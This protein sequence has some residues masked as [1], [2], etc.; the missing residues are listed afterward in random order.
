MRALSLAAAAETIR[1][2]GLVVFPTETVYGLGGDATDSRAVLRIYRLKSRPGQ[3]PL[4]IHV[5]DLKQAE[6]VAQFNRLA[7]RLARRFWPGPLTMVLPCRPGAVAREA[8]AGLETVA[9]RCPAHPLALRLLE[10]V[11]TPLAAPSAN[12][13]GRLSPTRAV[14]ALGGVECLDGG[15]CAVGIESTVVDLSA[16]EPSLLRPGV[17]TPEELESHF[18]SVPGSLPPKWGKTQK[19]KSPGMLGRHY[20]P[21]R[22]LRLNATSFRADEAALGF[23]AFPP[24]GEVRLN[25]SPR[26]DLRQAAANF[27]AMLAE[28]EK[29]SC[30]R[31]AVAPIPARGVGIALNDRLARAALPAQ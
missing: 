18:V 5:A 15:D 6:K 25:L 14:A 1:R 22:P 2:G 30:K 20:A 12:P 27:Y 7:R 16:A 31:I 11:A 8:T 9:V 10:R 13:S 29:S 21:A 26:G 3:N 19:I 23:G 4:I 17:I 24:G 28:L